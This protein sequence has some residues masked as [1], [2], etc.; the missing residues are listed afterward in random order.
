MADKDLMARIARHAAHVKKIT[1]PEWGVS[2][3]EPLVIYAP[4]MMGDVFE[5]CYAQANVDG[6]HNS[7]LFKAL[8]IFNQA[9]DKNGK[10]LFALTD[11]ATLQRADGD[12][13][14]RVAEQVTAAASVKDL[15]KN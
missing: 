3:S 11:V 6:Q 12:V 14:Q 15:E 2:A 1:V 5:S 13:L 8:L 4:A 7:T 10:K 9:Q